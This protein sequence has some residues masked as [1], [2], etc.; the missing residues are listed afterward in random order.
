MLGLALSLF[1]ELQSSMYLSTDFC[2]WQSEG[3]GGGFIKTHNKPIESSQAIKHKIKV[4]EPPLIK[5][6]SSPGSWV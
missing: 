4:K 2:P 3:N 1:S 6:E 5:V